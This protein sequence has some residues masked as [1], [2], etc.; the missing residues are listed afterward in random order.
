MMR[1][2]HILQSNL[3]LPAV[4]KTVRVDFSQTD[5]ILL[6]LFSQSQTSFRIPFIQF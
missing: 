1:Q 5:H 4:Y 3:P 2:E 6:G